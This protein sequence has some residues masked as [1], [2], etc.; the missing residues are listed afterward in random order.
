M[1]AQMSATA[2]LVAGQRRWPAFDVSETGEEVVVEAKVPGLGPE[3]VDVSVTEDAVIIRGVGSVMG[4]PRLANSSET[5][6]VQESPPGLCVRWHPD[7]ESTM[8]VSL[9]WPF[10]S[11]GF[12]RLVEGASCEARVLSARDH[13][14]SQ[15]WELGKRPRA[16]PPGGWLLTRETSASTRRSSSRAHSSVG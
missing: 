6:N 9:S 7:V 4:S 1:P 2:D 14:R 5:A 13:R 3:D 11:A 10:A 8:A 15:R 16:G 12:R